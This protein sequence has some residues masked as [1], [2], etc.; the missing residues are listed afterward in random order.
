M[1]PGPPH[2]RRSVHGR[3]R[4]W[5]VRGAPDATGKRSAPTR[6]ERGLVDKPMPE[7]IRSRRLP[8][9]ARFNCARRGSLCCHERTLRPFL[10]AL[11]ASGEPFAPRVPVRPSLRPLGLCHAP[12]RS[13]ER[14]R[15]SSSR[16][17]GMACTPPSHEP[18]GLGPNEPG[19]C[20]RPGE[21][22]RST[23]SRL[24]AVPGSGHQGR[25]RRNVSEPGTVSHG[26]GMP[27]HPR[28]AARASRCRSQRG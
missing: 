19:Y 25:Q 9:P 28:V 18:R 2:R 20:C 27:S 1:A 12:R 7:T 3:R 8:V 26:Q 11:S 24:H 10:E 15:I 4:R 14:P 23:A 16:P 5:S 6:L 21:K 13:L 22:Q 17:L